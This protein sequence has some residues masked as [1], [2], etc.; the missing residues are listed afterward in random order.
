[1]SGNEFKPGSSTKAQRGHDLLDRAVEAVRTQRLPAED[2]EAARHRTWQR[3]EHA[4]GQSGGPLPGGVINLDG[5]DRGAPIRGCEDVRALRKAYQTARLSDA[6]EVLVQAHLRECAA[7]RAVFEDADRGLARLAPWRTQAGRSATATAPAAVGGRAGRTPAGSRWPR[8]FGTAALAATLLAVAT[9]LFGDAFV[10]APSGYRATLE[11]SDGPVYVLGPGAPGGLRVLAAKGQ[12]HERDWLRTPRGSRAVIRLRDGS[13]VEVKPHSELGVS[14]TRK[15]TTVHL[16]RGSIIVRAAGRRTGHLM[17]AAGDATAVVTE[18]VFSAN[19]GT[20]GTRVSVIE[21]SVRVDYRGKQQI[22]GP[23]GQL[24]T[25][26]FV[27]VLPIRDEIAWSGEVEQYTASLQKTPGLAEELERH[28]TRWPELRYAS[29]LLPRLPRET[30]LYVAV[31]NYRDALRRAPALIE[32]HLRANT[33]LARWSQGDRT[34]GGPGPDQMTAPI[35]L[36]AE[37]HEFLGDEI[38]LAL[39]PTTDSRH[40]PA[41]RPLVVAEVKRP[42][43]RVFLERELGRLGAGEDIQLVDQ[44]GLQAGE[45]RPGKR[46]GLVLLA[47]DT[48][49]ALAAD[50]ADLIRLTGGPSPADPTGGFADT[51]FGARVADRYRDGAGLLFAA[52]LESITARLTRSGGEAQAVLRELGATNM[53]SLIVEQEDL[54]EVT[55]N[56]ASIDFGGPR[57]G[58]ASWLDAPAPMASLDFIGS[59]ATFAAAFVVKQPALVLDDLLR[60]GEAITPR[61]REDLQGLQARTGVELRQDLAATLGNDIAVAIDG[62]LLPVPSWK[63]VME[64]YDPDRLTRS[65]ERLVDELN[66]AMPSQGGR[67]LILERNASSRVL[68]ASASIVSDTYRVR[69][70]GAPFEA[71]LAFVDGY[72]VVAPSEQLLS[73]AARTRQSG[74][75]VRTSWRFRDLLPPDREANFSAVVYHNLGQAATRVGDLLAG[76]G[77]SSSK[78]T[79]RQVP[80]A[81]LEDSGEGRQAGPG[82]R[83]RG[84][85]RHPGGQRRRPVRIDPGPRG[86]FGG[87]IRPAPAG[88]P[89]TAPGA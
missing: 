40:S 3:L 21:G 87:I 68:R 75:T 33:A 78:D 53:K 57:T 54:G 69:V 61:L 47:T 71:H 36:F 73:R 76:A 64:V 50:R 31:P 49:V 74:R 30:L 34:A 14:M 62:P 35:R 19:R 67:R 45:Q 42:G 66:R 70:D 24:S 1:M 2:A 38:V 27:N 41:V 15:D 83:V 58:V 11:D 77:A 59:E 55:Q 65:L 29:V 32:E 81:A 20:K 25:S 26:R 23:G 12:L 13:R 51:P 89:R 60:L 22:L 44:T 7:C 10:G 84:R 17:V 6:R 52:D 18:S 8:Y 86:R 4:Q 48:Q 43:L 79:G 72:L 9:W 85:P 88:R 28:G 39:V 80:Q 82:L 56:R 37:L 63:L 46:P 5:S 16:E